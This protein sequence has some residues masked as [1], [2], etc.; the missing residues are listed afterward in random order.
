M[1]NEDPI[2]LN[3]STD[4][5]QQNKQYVASGGANDDSG[6]QSTGSGDRSNTVQGSSAANAGGTT[7]AGKAETPTAVAYQEVPNRRRHN[8]LAE[9]SSYTYQFTLYMITPDAY[10]RFVDSGRQKI[11]VLNQSSA[12]GQGGAFIICQNGGINNSSTK[13]A[14]GFQ[15][16]YYIDDVKIDSYINGKSTQSASNVT[17]ITFNIIEPLGFSFIS[18]LKRA[19][20]QLQAYCNTKNYKDLQNPSRQFFVLGVRFQGYDE[21]G[22]VMTGNQKGLDRKLDPSQSDNSSGI[23]ERFYDIIIRGIKFK[24]N[25]QATVYNISANSMPPGIAMGLKHGFTTKDVQITASTVRGAVTN[26]LDI[27]S[28]EQEAMLSKNQIKVKNTYNVVFQDSEIGDASIV[29]KADLTKFSYGMPVQKTA[30][31]TEAAAITQ[32]KPADPNEKQLKFTTSTPI[33]QAIENIISN[34]SYMRN[35]VESVYSNNPTESD[36]ILKNPDKAIIS[37]YNVSVKITNA[38]W[39]PQVGDYAYTITY[40]I[41]KYITPIFLSAYSKISPK[42]YGPHKVYEYWYTGKNTEILSYEQSLDNAYFNVAV[43]PSGTGQSQGGPTDVTTVPRGRTD[44]SKLSAIDKSLETI[45]TYVTSLYDPGSYAKVKMTIIGDPDFMI[46]DSPGSIKAVYDRFYGDDG[47]T[48]N[49][50]GGQVFIEINFKEADDYDTNTGV[51]SI[52]ESIRFWAYPSEIQNKVKGVS[53][54]VLR[55]TNNF[56]GGKFTQDLE[57]VI[58][59]FPDAPATSPNARPADPYANETAKFARQGTA[60]T[61]PL[62]AT[63]LRAAIDKAAG[64]VRQGTGISTDAQGKASPSIGLKSVDVIDSALPRVESTELVNVTNPTTQPSAIT[65]PTG[66]LPNSGLIVLDDDAHGVVSN[67]IANSGREVTSN[68]LLTP[69]VIARNGPQKL[70]ELI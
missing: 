67:P 69:D 34:S 45:N 33:L 61:T 32:N 4:T 42:Y 64:G 65:S 14:S 18:N 6:T 9:F 7:Q 40:Y 56:K 59:T 62:N 3:P 29:N 28:K 22:K 35:A 5:E 15:Y 8:P 1:A 36:N 68:A 66:G 58:N 39:D 25:G 2:L 16:D 30:Q 41:K 26:F 53:Y 37:W 31:S 38:E 63:T 51:L 10:D 19:A 24:V 52:N 70:D 21:N 60:P 48:I 55:V 20:D 12:K 57:C 43:V 54:M 17:D 27:L 11:D 47:F 44:Q 50:N 13:R 23:F 46:Q 49:A